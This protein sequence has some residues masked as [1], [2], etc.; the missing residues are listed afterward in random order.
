MKK[1]KNRDT[2]SWKKKYS[3]V[4]RIGS[5]GNAE[6]YCVK[7]SSDVQYAL[8]ELQNK[9]DKE[10]TARFLDEV[11]IMSEN[12]DISGIIPILEANIEEYWYVMPV[13]ETIMG[14]LGKST[15]RF[16]ETKKAI[17]QLTETLV[18][19]Q[20]REIAHRDIKPDNLYYY[21]DRYCYGD[22]GLVDFPDHIKDLTNTH[23]NLGAKF[24]IA[25]EM[26]RNPK[27][28]DGLKADIYSL[29]K[30]FWMLLT[31]DQFGFEGVYDFLDSS[32]G[33]RYNE[34]FKGVHLAEL[35]NLL[36]LATSNAPEDRP[37]IEQFQKAVSDWLE[38]SDDIEKSNESD[39]K[40]L[41]KLIFG[42]IIPKT[43]VWRNL[44]DIKEILQLLVSSPAYNHMLFSDNGGLDLD[45]IKFAPESG[46]LDLMVDQ[47]QV[48]RV[49]PK[50]LFFESF[51]NEIEWNYFRLELMD[52]SFVLGPLLNDMSYEVLTEDYPAHYVDPTDFCYGVYDYDTGE[53]LPKDARIIMRYTKGVLLIVMKLGPY[54]AINATYDGRHGD[55]NNVQFR[56]YVEELV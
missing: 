2:S 46:W 23:R 40:F 11:K 30:T 28:A 41:A 55:C 51:G 45:T 50:E 1:T 42:D 35:E 54:N 12:L 32:Y 38:I 3:F 13:A 8:K 4:K 29:A 34:D 31:D 47:E 21:N 52:E 53:P 5:G 33:L 22:F 6:V 43:V 17:K 26:M 7:D 44:N 48:Y 39:W 20:K 10:K 49:R 9:K 27:D 24:T 18:Q 19:L 56:R 16:L 36:R 37:T 14:H 15:D 25:P